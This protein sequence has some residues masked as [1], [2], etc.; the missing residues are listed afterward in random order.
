MCV[1]IP[2]QLTK[3]TGTNA[4]AHDGSHV[5]LSLV[6]IQPVGTWV[7]GFLGTARSVI[8]A[9]EA[10]LIAKALD[11]LRDVMAGGDGGDAF[12]DIDARGP[13]LPPHLQAALDA[14]RIT[15]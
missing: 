15:G 7:L 10:T 13:Q 11:G 9:E 1:G 5:D 2:L 14:G 4:L 8:D 6:G 3:V 12:A